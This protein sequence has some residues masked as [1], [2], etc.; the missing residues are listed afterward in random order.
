MPRLRRHPMREV[1]DEATDSRSA[2]TGQVCKG[3]HT[4]VG[5]MRENPTS[6]GAGRRDPP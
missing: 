2:R 4:T 5:V 3:G 1:I 6:D